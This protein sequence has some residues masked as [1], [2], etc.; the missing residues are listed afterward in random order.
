MTPLVERNTTIPEEKKNVF[1]T[2]TDNQT[3]VTVRVFE[4]ERKMA[5]NNRL[6]GEVDLDNIP[7]APRG[8]PQIEVRFDID[9]NGIL[10]VAAKDLGTSEEASVRI[11]QSGGLSDDDIERMRRE[12]E[13][14]QLDG[15]TTKH[16]VRREQKGQAVKD[17][18]RHEPKFHTQ[19]NRELT[20]LDD[21]DDSLDDASGLPEDY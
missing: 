2:A 13:F 3:G 15:H 17:H 21:E 14:E 10:H 16:R 20:L 11:E 5:A 18:S 19:G 4:G 1:S 8:A 12:L 7:A 9:Q 6:L